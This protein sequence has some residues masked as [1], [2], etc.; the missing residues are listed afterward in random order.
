MPCC[1]KGQHNQ[2]RVGSSATAK[3]K[4]NCLVRYAVVLEARVWEVF[5]MW[6]G[7]CWV[8]VRAD[9]VDNSGTAEGQLLP[10][11]LKQRIVLGKEGLDANKIEQSI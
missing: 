8:C 6:F 5:G 4:C 2:I 9:C 11:G 1:N 3:R 7:C 10:H